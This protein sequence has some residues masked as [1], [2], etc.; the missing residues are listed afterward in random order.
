MKKIIA[1]KYNMDESVLC[2]HC[3]STVKK[4]GK[5]ILLTDDEQIHIMKYVNICIEWG[6]PINAVELRY[7]VKGYLDGQ[8]RSIEGFKDNLPPPSFGI[9]FLERFKDVLSYRNRFNSHNRIRV[10][11][12]VDNIKAYFKR[13]EVA[14]A[15]IEP[16]N[17]LH[18]DETNFSEHLEHKT[19]L[20]KRKAKYPERMKKPSYALTSVMLAGTGAGELLPPYVVHQAKHLYD[21]WTDN[22]PPGTR[23]NRSAT[24][25]FDAQVFKDWILSIVL[26]YFSNKKGMKCLIGDNLSSHLSIDVIKLCHDADIR[27]F[28]IPAHTK[29]L[30]QPL[31]V[32]LNRPLKIAWQSVFYRWHESQK[33]LKKTI[34]K[35][36]FPK[37]LKL[38][39]SYVSRNAKENILRGFKDTGI[40]PVNMNEILKRIPKGIPLAQQAV[41]Q[42][43]SVPMC[44]ELRFATIKKTRPRKKRKIK[45]P[46]GRSF[47]IDDKIENTNKLET[48]EIEKN[49]TVS[50]AALTTLTEEVNN[51]RLDYVTGT[52]AHKEMERFPSGFRIIIDDREIPDLK[53]NEKKIDDLHPALI[54]N[55]PKIDDVNPALIE[56]SQHIDKIHPALEE[57]FQQIDYAHPASIENL[58]QI[59]DVHPA[60]IENVHQIDDVHPALIENGQQTED[61][62]F[63]DLSDED[64][65]IIEDHVEDQ[66][67]KVVNNQ[68]VHTQF[69][70][71]GIGEINLSFLASPQSNVNLLFDKNQ[72]SGMSGE[73]KSQQIVDGQS[74]VVQQ[75]INMSQHEPTQHHQTV[76]VVSS[77]PSSLTQHQVQ[78][79]GAA[80]GIQQQAG[81]GIS[82]MPS[83]QT[84][85]PNTQH[86]PQISAD[87]G[88]SRVQVIQQPLQNNTYL[89]QLYNAQGPLL[90]PGNIALHP[91]INS[92]PIQVI[93]ASKP[94]QGSQLA[95]HMLTAQGKQVLQGQAAPFPGYTTIPAIPTTQNQT[96]VFSPLGVINSQPNILPAHSQPTVSAISQQ[97]KAQEMHKVLTGKVS[98]S[99]V[100]GATVPVQAQCVQVSQVSQPVLGQQPQA[101]II[102]PLQAGGQAMQFAPWQ[103]SGALPQVWA[104]GGLQAGTIPAGGLLAPNPIFIRGSQPDAPPSM[105]IQHS[106]QNNVQHASV[107]VACATATTSKPRASTDGLAK[108]PRPLTNILPSTSIRPAS[109]VS[110]QTNANAQKQRGKPGVRSPAPTTKQDAANQTNKVQLNQPKQQLLVMNSSG[111]MTQ[112]TSVQD[113]QPIT[114][115]I[116]QQ[117]ILQQ[118]ALQQQQA[119]QQQQ[120]QQQLLQQQQTQ[121]LLNQHYQ[122][123]GMTLG[124]QQGS[125]MPQISM[126]QQIHPTLVGG[127]LVQTSVAMAVQPQSLNHTTQM[128]TVTANSLN[129]PQLTLQTQ[130]AVGLLA[131]SVPGSMLPLAAQ[132]A[133]VAQLKADE[134]KPQPATITVQ[135]L[136]SLDPEVLTCPESPPMPAV[137]TTADAGISTTTGMDSPILIESSKSSPTRMDS[138]T[139][140]SET[141]VTVSSAVSSAASTST[142]SVTVSAAAPSPVPTSSVTASFSLSSVTASGSGSPGATS[143]PSTSS[144][145]TTSPATSQLAPGKY[146][147]K[148]KKSSRHRHSRDSRGRA[149]VTTVAS[150]T[151]SSSTM[152]SAITAPVSSGSSI[153]KS[154]SSHSRRESHS[155]HGQSSHRSER[156]ISQATH[157]KG[158]P[159][160]MVKPNILTHVIEGYVIQE[161]GEPFAKCFKKVNRPLREWAAPDKDHD[162]ENKLQSE[163]PPRK[164]AMLEM[165]RTSSR[166]SSSNE[167]TASTPLPIAESP[168]EIMDIEPEEPQP[169]IPNANKWTVSEVCEF[170]RNIPGCSGYADEFL[171]QEVDGE[172]LLLI[173][174]E[175]LVMALSM[176]LG[177]ALKIVACIDSLRPEGENPT[178]EVD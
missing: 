4:K 116:Q 106:P 84:L 35:T 141:S 6:Y 115:N 158:L 71:P 67:E 149:V 70:V 48:N 63:S 43:E 164:K 73:I 28:F 23:Y 31:D 97:Q 12:T 79:Q 34:P 171:L 45:I 65:T 72:K 178:A 140:T 49:N 18:Y 21:T 50:E 47:C 139:S 88:H 27:F 82:T 9:K 25:W 53:E 41:I 80:G 29:L 26:P 177:P 136:P 2:R 62:Y 117:S 69:N 81:A 78:Q 143:S 119:Q 176:K 135:Q 163:E 172:A 154:K 37:L 150:S 127:N 95:P 64:V 170:V 175:H 146:K 133:L 91:G 14:L 107:S 54:E 44:A 61:V 13:M 39:M 85:P 173:R 10:T 3:P 151:S 112:I 142:S 169:K 22:G 123:Q 87:W 161:A 108:A 137:I 15:N 60:S 42:P 98:A 138:S 77:M 40:C 11:L 134:E 68:P 120:H 153:F 101:Q 129:S 105:F 132:T 33:W 166:I 24:G 157:D 113:K 104:A 75:Q 162:K 38:V 109:S 145:T 103:I 52:L 8:D 46:P 160:A 124:M 147:V 57:N 148:S 131:A 125:S 58:H 99:K 16:C 55:S 56:N 100:G 128:Q 86:P 5:I 90:M 7:L 96:F 89:Q 20:T 76:T 19:T 130:G 32:A 152:T 51:S 1:E 110:T 126:V 93:A 174:P 155:T 30:N 168:V 83:L 92:Q 74:Q 66:G 167:S 159:K 121:Q 36:E 17:I 59:D 156:H 94:F 102:S 114:K 122:S 144:A 165:E 111:Q 118:Q